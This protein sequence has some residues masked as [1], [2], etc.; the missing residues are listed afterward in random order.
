MSV[1]AD[2][3]LRDRYEPTPRERAVVDANFARAREKPP[4]PA[5]K[6][7][8]ENGVQII[9]ADHLDPSLALTGC[10]STGFQQFNKFS[11]FSKFSRFT[12]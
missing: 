4:A 9:D 3:N 10:A 8:A 6:I 2:C 1:P 5:V 11:R 7:E 12:R